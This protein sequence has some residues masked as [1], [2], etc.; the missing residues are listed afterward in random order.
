MSRRNRGTTSEKA[1]KTAMS[2]EKTSAKTWPNRYSAEGNVNKCP[3][4]GSQVDTEAYHCPA[5]QNYFCY[6]CR[7]R[8]S[9]SEKHLQCI[10]Q[11]CNYYGKLLCDVCDQF[12]EREE[13][14]LVY[15]EPED[16]YW[17]AWI[18]IVLIASCLVWYWSSLSIALGF[19]IVTFPLF[20]WLLQKAGLNIFGTT[21]MVEQPKRI[22]YF[23]CVCCGERA[24]EVVEFS[25]SKGTG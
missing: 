8:L 2:R 16:G 21:R 19:A 4:C 9:L 20:G 6:H 17:P 14:P 10:N 1:S 3:V 13:S 11:N 18:V 24:K 5:C 12:T 7:A 15:A 25:G 23:T 22:S